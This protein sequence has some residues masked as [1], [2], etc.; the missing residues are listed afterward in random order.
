MWEFKKGHLKAVYKVWNL[1]KYN[2]FLQHE[3]YHKLMQ[4]YMPDFALIQLNINQEYLKLLLHFLIYTYSAI[5]KKQVIYLTYV[6][7]WLWKKYSNDSLSDKHFI[8]NTLHNN[9]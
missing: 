3:Y 4:K 6:S 2:F 9:T 7:I 8:R 5:K 1:G